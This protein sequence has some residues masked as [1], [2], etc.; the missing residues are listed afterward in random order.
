[1]STES[2]LAA[3]VAIGSLKP[4]RCDQSHETTISR[5]LG[6]LEKL[7]WLM[8]QHR[9]VHFA[10]AAEVGGSTRIAQWQDALD[11]VCRQSALIWSRIVPDEHGTPAF[12]PVPRGSIPLHVVTTAASRWAVYVA[13]QLQQPFDTSKAPLVRAT[14]LRGIDRSVIILCA[15]HAIADGLSLSFLVRDLLRA[16]A[17]EPVTLNPE[18]AS[19]EHLV[20]RKLGSVAWPVGQPPPTA[21]A[22]MQ[23][24][25][26]DGS[27]P[28][29]A[30]ARLTQETTQRLRER[31]RA[32]RTTL[33]GALCAAATAAAATAMSDWVEAPLR[34]LSPVDIRRSVLDSSEHLGVCVTAVVLEDET[35][36]HD[37]WSRARSFSERLATAKSVD[38]ISALVGVMQESASQISTVQ[39]AQEFVAQGFGSEIILTNLGDIEFQDS[40]GPFTLDALWGPSVTIGFALGQTIG[41]VTVGGR[42]HLLHTSYKPANGLL[43]NASAIL[44]AALE[45]SLP[46]RPRVA[47]VKVSQSSRPDSVAQG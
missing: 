10:I 4:F 43:D 41:A 32:E 6:A 29:V 16:L 37:F 34:V 46:S 3:A 17:G 31:A 35:N 2:K 36:T 11:R 21:R 7:F 8:D 19:L 12:H 14:L 40:Y 39:Q 26:K 27:K 47:P 38:G 1:M 24:R 5:P 13:R 25:P 28:H 33:H 15:H 9:P 22:P 44:N 42:L 45:D 30:A 20:S 23:Y 18:T